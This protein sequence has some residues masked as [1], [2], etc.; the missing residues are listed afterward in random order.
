M[1]RWIVSLLLMLLTP[2]YIVYASTGSDVPSVF[3]FFQVILSLGLI[4]LFIFLFFRFI[5]K[6]KGFN[7]TGY[8]QHLGGIPLGQN[9]T[10]QMVEIGNKLYILGVGENVQLISVVEDKEELQAIKESNSF[11]REQG[12]QLVDWIQ[13]KMKRNA[14]NIKKE[15][16][17]HHIFTEKMEQFKDRRSESIQEWLDES[18]ERIGNREHHE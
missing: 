11:Q 13:E 1:Y 18:N 6:K 15:N 17:F 5:A 8:Y 9:K 2:E 3:T 4:L 7:K 14:Q 10:L 16:R 12:T